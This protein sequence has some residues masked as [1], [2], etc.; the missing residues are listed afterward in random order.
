MKAARVIDYE[1]QLPREK[2]ASFFVP[3]FLLSETDNR[4]VVRQTD[5]SDGRFFSCCCKIEPPSSHSSSLCV[6]APCSAIYALH[7][8]HH[9]RSLHGA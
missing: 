7:L 9:V 8:S 5:D 6:H 2:Q 1:N 4:D 3:S